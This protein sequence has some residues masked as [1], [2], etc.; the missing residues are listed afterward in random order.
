[1]NTFRIRLKVGLR[2][3]QVRY[4]NGIV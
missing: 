3:F 2:Q 4:S 1:V